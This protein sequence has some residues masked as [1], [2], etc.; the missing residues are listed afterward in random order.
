MRQVK[1]L[2]MEPDYT[3]YTHNELLDAY[4]SVDKE[5]HPLRSQRLKSLIQEKTTINSA[6]KSE[7]NIDISKKKIDP[8]KVIFEETKQ[9]Y[10]YIRWA[11]YIIFLSLAYLFLRETNSS[12]MVKFLVY[13][14]V[15][16]LNS[17][18]WHVIYK[19]RLSNFKK[20]SM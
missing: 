1:K 6:K 19:I 9:Q 11:I 3:Y 13:L 8:I 15:F 2:H 18:I 17:F 5:L 10:G 7:V 20:Y 4:S 16:L 14:G 12:S